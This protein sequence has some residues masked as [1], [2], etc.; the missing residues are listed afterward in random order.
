[1]GSCQALLFV[2]P[3]LSSANKRK[4]LGSD[5]GRKSRERERKRVRRVCDSEV[6]LTRSGY[7]LSRSDVSFLFKNLARSGRF[8]NGEEIRAREKNLRMLGRQ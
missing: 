4:R 5:E 1:L 6:D 8:K 2:L 3:L 7:K